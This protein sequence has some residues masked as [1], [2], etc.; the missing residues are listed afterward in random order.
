[1][2][3]AKV[4]EQKKYVDFKANI[5]KTTSNFDNNNR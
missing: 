5:G 4:N 3:S 2:F 1:M